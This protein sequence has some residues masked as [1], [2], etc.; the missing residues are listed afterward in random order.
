MAEL[1]TVARP[2]AEAAFRA[3]LDKGSLAPTGDALALLAAVT[4]DERV[5][6]VMSDPRVTHQQKKDLLASIAG[7]RLDEVSRNLVG[8]LVDNRR[9]ELIGAIAEEFDALKHEH[10]RVVKARITSAQPLSDAQRAEIVGALERR[11][12][13]KVEAELDVDPE[14]L[15]GARVQVGDQVIHASVRDALAQMAAALTR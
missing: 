6:S 15:G 7:S 8:V 12:G 14:L 3:A 5:R 4:A 11:Y 10:E 9:E 1:A 13:K 2:Y